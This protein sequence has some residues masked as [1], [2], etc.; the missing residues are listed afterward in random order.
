[1][2]RKFTEEETIAGLK[3]NDERIF[4][5]LFEEFFAPLHYFASSLVQDRDEAEDIIIGIFSTFWNMRSNFGSLTNIKAFLYISAKNRC[6]NFLQY[7][8]RQS[9]GKKALTTHLMS[10]ELMEE[11]DNR[12]VKS[13]FLNQVFKE[14]QQLPNQCREIFMLTYYAGMTSGEIAGK[15]NIS[16]GAVT[17]QRSRAI[18][19]LKS[20]LK[21]EDLLP[22]LLFLACNTV[23]NISL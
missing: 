16:V 13:D 8:E 5:E 22:F 3:T 7:R 2:I 17:T 20:I 9:A 18:K 6:L 1:M 14:V 10:S 19:Y 23:R 15:L 12:I 21:E 11:T 4:N